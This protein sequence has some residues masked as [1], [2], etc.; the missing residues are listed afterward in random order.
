MQSYDYRFFADSV[1]GYKLKIRV[2]F[3]RAF[4]QLCRIITI[5]STRTT[6]IEDPTT[7]LRQNISNR[8]GPTQEVK[9]K[10][11]SY[12]FALLLTQFIIV[13]YLDV[14]CRKCFLNINTTCTVNSRIIAYGHVSRL[15]MQLGVQIK[16]T[17][18]LI[19]VSI[20]LA[21]SDYRP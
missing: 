14:S 7:A 18:R 3:G 20:L 16:K 9:N 6:Y 19:L 11:Q 13:E 4:C 1:N 2:S 8:F 21:L 5:L 17:M 15:T 12:F 10:R